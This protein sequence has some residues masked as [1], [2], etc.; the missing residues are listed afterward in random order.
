MHT[1]LTCEVDKEKFAIMQMI[2]RCV[3]TNQEIPGHSTAQIQQ[4]TF[5][6]FAPPILDNKWEFKS[7]TVGSGCY[8]L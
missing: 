4:K 1:N 7:G 5:T 8:L 3:Y 2:L 6:Y